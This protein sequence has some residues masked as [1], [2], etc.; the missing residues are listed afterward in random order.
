ML[1]FSMK[2]SLYNHRTVNGIKITVKINDKEEAVLVDVRKLREYAA[3]HPER[4]RKRG[5]LGGLQACRWQ[6][7]H[8]D[9][10]TLQ[11]RFS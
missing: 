1:I 5:V 7:G 8:P 6:D 10:D 4:E 11:D 9:Y 3:G 2:I